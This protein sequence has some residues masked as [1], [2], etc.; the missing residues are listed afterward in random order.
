MEKRE[1]AYWLERLASYYES[2]GDDACPYERRETTALELAAKA[3]GGSRG[4][5]P[6]K[7]LREEKERWDE[8]EGL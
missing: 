2:L 5:Q 8:E 7:K 3:L 1:A 6:P 4:W